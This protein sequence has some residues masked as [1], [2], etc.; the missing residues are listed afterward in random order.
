MDQDET[1]APE[2]KESSDKRRKMH[3]EQFQV[4]GEI[5]PSI[6]KEPLKNLGRVYNSSVTDR[7][8]KD[9]LKKKIKE[10]VQKN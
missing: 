4:A 5:I 1:K 6:Q 9:E 8:A 2:I 3:E 7:K 10:L